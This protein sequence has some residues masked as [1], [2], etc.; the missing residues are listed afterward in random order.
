MVSAPIGVLALQGDFEDHLTMLRAL[1][2]TARTV[3]RVEDLQGLAGLFIPGGESS[4]MIRLLDERGLRPALLARVEQGMA[5]MGTCAGAILLAREADPSPGEPLGL[6]DLSVRRNDYGRQIESFVTSITI[7][8][9][10]EPALGAVFI[11]AP[12]LTRV[13]S[14]IEILAHHAGDP[15]VVLQDVPTRPLCLALSF[16]PELRHDAR[17]H[18]LFLERIAARAGLRAAA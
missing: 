17:L 9:F 13:G 5:V 14:D 15:V 6:M 8:Q 16:H 18:R 11:R 1:G 10:G 4:V 3:R 12:R 7:P 2:V